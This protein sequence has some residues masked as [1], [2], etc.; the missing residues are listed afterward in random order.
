M[1][2]PKFIHLHVHTAYSLSEGA[3]PIKKLAALAK[4]LKM[5]ALA[6]TDTS[7][8][9]GAL[10]F[11]E[12]LFEKGV[13]PIIGLRLRVDLS[14]PSEQT[15]S[16]QTGLK[17]QTT[18]VLLAKDEDGYK[19]L[20]KLSSSSFLEVP[21]NAEPHV[22]WSKLE[23]CSTGLICL[24]GGPDGPLNESL[25]QNQISLAEQQAQQL[26]SLFG[27][28]LYIELQ[29]H[30]TEAEQAAEPGLIEIAYQ[31]EIP[32]VATNQCYFATPD[33]YVAHDALICIA[34]GEV[35][36]TED[37]RRLTPEHY[38]KSQDEMAA[39]FADLPEALENTIEIAKRCAFRVKLCRW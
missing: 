29:R 37:R 9:F 2:D 1:A 19:N 16:T 23:T 14:R 10:E 17:H 34:A 13:Q 4:A 3:L 22:T 8:L 7:N 15:R 30:G 31:Q 32:L 39:L 27:D 26:K 35:I 21:D 28:R 38:F 20:M 6:A 33:D 11:S 36:A 5:P 18:I 25:V 24:T 12:A